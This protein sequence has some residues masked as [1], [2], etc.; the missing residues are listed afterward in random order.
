MAIGSNLDT[1]QESK[2]ALLFW[3]S[4]AELIMH[5]TTN[6]IE[7]FRHQQPF[8]V[9]MVAEEMR[10]HA[11]PCYT[12]EGTIAGLVFARPV[13]PA[14]WIGIEYIVMV[15]KSR[16]YEAK[17]IVNRFPIDEEAL[18]VKWAEILGPALMLYVVIVILGLVISI[19]T[20]MIKPFTLP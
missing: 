8:V 17:R 3:N 10:K 6:F 2:T 4:G 9:D 11:I 14:A 13:M 7:V 1:W 19:I 5:E 16:F 15:P 18:K 12:Q 20:T